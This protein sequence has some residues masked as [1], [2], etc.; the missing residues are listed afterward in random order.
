[1]SL[2]NLPKI[3]FEVANVHGGDYS[4]FKK[5]IKYYN[6]INYPNKLK[7]I[8]FQVL[9]ANEISTPEYHWYKTYKKLYFSPDQWKN[10]IR[11]SNIKT[12][13][14][15]DLFDNYSFEILKKNLNYIHG[16]KLQPSILFN[17]NLYNSLRTINLKKKIVILNI[18]GLSL[19]KI[20]EFIKKFEILK[21]KKII[22]QFGFQSYPTEIKDT[23]LNKVFEIKKKFPKYDFC[24]A[25]HADASNEFSIDVP[26]YS[27][28]IGAKFLEKHFCLSRKK[29]PYDKYSSLEPKQI[30]KLIKKINS[31]DRAFGNSFINYKEQKYLLDSIQIPVTKKNSFFSST[32][33]N[34]DI[35]FKRTDKKGLSFEDLQKLKNK[36]YILIKNKKI[37][38]TYQLADFKKAKI[39]ILVTGRMK[40]SRLPRKALKKIGNLSSIELCLK[41]CK[42]VSKNIKVILATSFLNEDKILVKKYK[43]KYDV[44]AGHPEDVIKRFSDAAKKYK[45]DVVVRVTGDCP[46]V[47][48]E[49]INYL[50]DN[51]F[52]TGADYTA[53]KKFAVGTTGEVYNVGALNFILKKMK[54]APFSEYMP[55]YFLNNK[56]YFKINIVELPKHL[57]RKHRLTLDYDDDLLMFNKLVNVSQQSA[58]RLSTKT[59]FNIL[60]KSSNISRINS[61]FKLIYL[62]KKFQKK[63][64]KVTTFAQ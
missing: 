14:W 12:N 56:N 24:M 17:K 15:L 63:L 42:K 54:K 4:H 19:S 57:V 6:S 46:F 53:A 2:N 62:T 27:K 22:I 5:I 28:L 50:I 47:S 29:S 37:N 55:W 30:E 13:I 7:S 58:S 34:N 23:N 32:L 52:S 10:I 40:S 49:I 3:I 20:N 51:H 25:D 21:P 1:M 16:F 61:K 44:F 33:A 43:K 45:L 36:K 8:K 26:I 11:K 9:N 48:P 59:I 60:D 35:S 31:L 39:G 18:S 64:K 41:N 38:Q